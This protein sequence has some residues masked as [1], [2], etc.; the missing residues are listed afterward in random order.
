MEGNICK[1]GIKLETAGERFRRNE[2]TSGR[3][4]VS[5]KSIIPKV[6]NLF[7]FI[8]HVPRCE[9]LVIPRYQKA[10]TF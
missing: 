10:R 7:K 9:S 4:Q 1:S 5:N 8:P 6:S 3:N 2:E